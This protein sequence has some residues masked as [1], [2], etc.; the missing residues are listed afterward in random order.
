MMMMLLLLP[1]WFKFT[2][3]DRV[4][5]EGVIIIVVVAV[6]AI[7]A[8]DSAAVKFLFIVNVV[9]VAAKARERNAFACCLAR[10]RDAAC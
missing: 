3:D 2:F 8:M 9:L 5:R 1:T 4:W 7:A 6:V 10:N